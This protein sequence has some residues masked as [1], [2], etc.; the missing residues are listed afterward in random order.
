MFLIHQP[1][2][3]YISE[4]FRKKLHIGGMTDFM[5]LCT[6]GLAA[7]CGISYVFFLLFE[8]PFMNARRSRKPAPAQAISPAVPEVA[9]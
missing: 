3:W 8:K 1:T 5:L 6:I 7:V 9:V 4:F 2:A